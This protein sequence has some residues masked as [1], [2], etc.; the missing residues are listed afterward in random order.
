MKAKWIASLGGMILTLTH[1]DYC[2][3]GAYLDAYEE[4]LKQL[5]EIELAWRALPS[6]AAA[7]WQQ[8][9]PAAVAWFENDRPHHNWSRSRARDRG[10]A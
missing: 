1:P 8:R 3:D 6:E 10:P 2:G 9:A 5:G 4:L 7:W